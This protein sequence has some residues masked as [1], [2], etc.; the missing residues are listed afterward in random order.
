LIL[1]QPN[2]MPRAKQPILNGNR[3]LLSIDENGER[4]SDPM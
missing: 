2:V 3:S 4:L 1:T